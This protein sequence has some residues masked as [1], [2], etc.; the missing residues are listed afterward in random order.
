MAG[1]TPDLVDE[2]AQSTTA[3]GPL[4]G[5]AREDFIGASSTCGAGACAASGVESCVG[6][7]IEGSCTPGTPAADNVVH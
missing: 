3:L 7:A 2:A 6:G 1:D 4:M 5:L